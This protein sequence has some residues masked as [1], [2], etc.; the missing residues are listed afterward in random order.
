MVNGR[1][2]KCNN[3]GECKNNQCVCNEYFEGKHCDCTKLNS[4]CIDQDHTICS[5]RGDCRC[6][7]CECTGQVT[8]HGQY[9]EKCPFCDAPQF[10]EQIL[11]CVQPFSDKFCLKSTSL[12][13][14]T[15][16]MNSTI[17]SSDENVAF[18]KLVSKEGLLPNETNPCSVH[19]EDCFAITKRWRVSILDEEEENGKLKPS[20]EE[21]QP[22]TMPNL[23][24]QRSFTYQCL[25]VINGCAVSYSFK[26][27]YEPEDPT[28]N[29]G[30]DTLYFE[31]SLFKEICPQPVNMVV[32][33]SSA[34]FAVLFIGLLTICIWKLLTNYLDRKEYERFIMEVDAANFSEVRLS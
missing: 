7:R 31:I 26:L 10:C 18:A 32:V 15:A 12:S 17:V 23:Q 25:K 19:P 20:S 30:K 24:N 22:E 33:G 3:Q 5:G 13:L 21:A 34:L 2:V 28:D 6:G 27:N 14:S 4:T 8:A 11:S 29:N 1:E 9:C 16:E